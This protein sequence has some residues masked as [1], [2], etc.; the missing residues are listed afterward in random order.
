MELHLMAVDNLVC[1]FV[2][3]QSLQAILQ[4]ISC[5]SCFVSSQAILQAIMYYASCFV[6]SPLGDIGDTIDNAIDNPPLHLICAAMAINDMY[7]FFYIS[8]N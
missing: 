7:H 2:C 5:V 8:A 1:I 3:C 6:F 4:A